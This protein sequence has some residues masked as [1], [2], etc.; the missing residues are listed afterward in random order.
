MRLE[1]ISV[2]NPKIEQFNK[3]SVEATISIKIAVCEEDKDEQATVLAALTEIWTRAHVDCLNF[4]RF[5]SGLLV[6]VNKTQN[7]PDAQP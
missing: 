5:A 1:S 7:E 4:V 3:K 2:Q 6:D